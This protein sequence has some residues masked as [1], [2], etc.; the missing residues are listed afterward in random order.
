M[1]AL[2]RTGH[3]RSRMGKGTWKCME[4]WNLLHDFS[5][6]TAWEAAGT[7]QQASVDLGGGHLQLGQAQ[8]TCMYSRDWGMRSSGSTPQGVGGGTFSIY[9]PQPASCTLPDLH[10]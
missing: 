5:G 9:V 8:S 7:Y 3:C 10:R 6:F 1:S 2:E 4:R